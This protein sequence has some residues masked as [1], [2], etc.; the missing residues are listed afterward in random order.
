MAKSNP[1]KPRPIALAWIYLVSIVIIYALETWVSERGWLASLITYLPQVVFLIP[2]ALLLIPAFARRDRRSGRIVGLGMT[3]ALILLMRPV[4]PLARFTQHAGAGRERVRV[5]QYNVE[6]WASGSGKIADAIISLNPDVVC[7]E[8]AD[9]Y[10]YTEPGA[11]HLMMLLPNY[12]W[13]H[14]G[15]VLVG[16]KFPILS[17]RVYHIQPDEK[18]RATPEVEVEL[19]GGG[20]LKIFATHLMPVLWQGP[21]SWRTIDRQRLTECRNLAT[22]LNDAGEPWILCGDLNMPAAGVA[23]RTL[24]KSGKSALDE[25]GSGF[26]YTLTTT[27]PTE[28]VDHVIVDRQITVDRA[29]IGNLRLSDHLPIIVDLRLLDCQC[30]DAW[31]ERGMVPHDVYLGR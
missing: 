14:A 5:M 21:D 6:K 30:R 17:T 16:S 1:S 20:P 23:Y 10:F 15:E 19:P 28:R 11:S 25:A 9:D 4:V 8:E 29:I 26:G 24:A 12:H 13:V 22:T 18:P 2:G 31:A 3:V 7:L 27:I